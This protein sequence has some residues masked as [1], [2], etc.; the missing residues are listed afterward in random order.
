[1][2]GKLVVFEGGEGCGKTT[3]LLKLQTWIERS[4]W[5]QHLQAQGHLTQLL[6]TREPGGTELGQTLR[7]LL[8][9]PAQ[10][11]LHSR[12]ELLL[13]AADRSQ[14]V[15]QVLRP[16]L[17]QGALILCD[18]YTDSTLAYQGFGRGIGVELIQQLN[19]VATDG[20]ESDLTF[21]LDVS[22][23]VGLQRAQRRGAIDRIE[24]SD[25]EFH[26]RVYQGFAELARLYPQ[27]IIRIDAS[28]PEAAV[29]HQIQ[30]VL[31]HHL[32]QWYPT[33]LA[34]S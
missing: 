7:S 22:V 23:E 30:T 17:Q 12:A 33:V 25:L 16:G 18:R 13:Y 1:M 2:N 5:M 32:S 4:K 34:P 21:W 31:Q 6:T 9:T 27:R 8:L 11:P 3:Q 10:A 20:L 15:E 29:A 26:Q 14:H 28:L 19:L 24:Q